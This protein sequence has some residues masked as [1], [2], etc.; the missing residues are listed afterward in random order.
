MYI[1]IYIHVCTWRYMHIIIYIV[2]GVNISEWNKS[3]I[4]YAHKSIR[5]N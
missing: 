2:H 1:L 4:Y 5:G 3:S